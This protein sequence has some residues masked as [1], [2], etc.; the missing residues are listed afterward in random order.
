[1]K[2]TMALIQAEFE[3]G[4]LDAN[5]KKAKEKI[6]A[7]EKLGANFAL[8]PESF[9]RGYS[10]DGMQQM[11]DWSEALDGRTVT[12][13]AALAQRLGIYL[14]VP[15]LVRIPDGTCENTAVLLSDSGEII[16][17]YAKVNLVSGNEALLL[18]AGRSY[19]VFKTKFGKIGIIIC[20]DL[21]SPTPIQMLH[22]N[23][24]ELILLP[25]AWRF[26]RDKVGWWDDWLRTRA[27]DYNVVIAAVNHIGQTDDMLF[28]GASRIV[29]AQGNVL[30][31]STFPEED[32]LI[33]EIVL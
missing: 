9:N 25:A 27:R 14:L 4:N 17:T 10:S 28:Y 19:P 11:V 7:A 31:A 20:N 23:G 12:E 6:E 22:D 3:F 24:A 26:K 30:I 2:L 33:Q 16:G 13:M 29:D 1:M 15:L 18:S 5:L 32:T 21:A 8:L